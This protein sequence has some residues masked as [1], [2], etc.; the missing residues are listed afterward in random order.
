MSWLLDIIIVAIIA[1]TV[2]FA[3]KNGFVKTAISAGSFIIAVALTFCFAS[4]LAEVLKS[5]SIAE[6]IETETEEKI[7]TV[8]LDSSLGI[9]QLLSGES[10][11]FNTLVAVSGIEI[12]GRDIKDGS[13]LSPTKQIAKLLTPPIVSTIA[14]LLAIIII[15]VGARII[16]A[17][18]AKI[19]DGVM[20]LPILKTFNKLLGVALGVVLAV[21]RVCVFCFIVNILINNSA[22]LGLDF[23]GAINPENTL[24]FNL[25][26][27]L[28]IFGFMFNK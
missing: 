18:I 14:L 23:I 19:L 28:E 4:P 2:Y 9:D 8:M 7:E 15:Y 25:F 6:K 21:L 12:S 22:F 10:E 17:I 27:N 5:T 11:A 1:V 24:L 26:K 13:E 20:R 16:L 3:A